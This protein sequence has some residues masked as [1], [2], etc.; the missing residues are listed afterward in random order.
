VT[1]TK[2]PPANPGR[3]KPLN[4]Q[5]AVFEGEAQKSKR[6]LWSAADLQHPNKILANAYRAGTAARHGIEPRTTP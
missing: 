1:Q 5:Y 3:F 2:R 6:G 4:F